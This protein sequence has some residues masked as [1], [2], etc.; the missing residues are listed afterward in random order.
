[1]IDISSVPAST[2]IAPSELSDFTK[3][4][5]YATPSS[6]MVTAPSVV[7]FPPTATLICEFTDAAQTAT[8]TPTTFAMGANITMQPLEPVMLMYT[9]GGWIILG[10]YGVVV[11]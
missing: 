1:M 11:A 3:K 9:T 8:V 7:A 6:F 2:L 4:S 10:H 5:T